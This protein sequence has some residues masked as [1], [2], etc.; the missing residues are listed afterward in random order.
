MSNSTITADLPRVE[1]RGGQGAAVGLNNGKPDQ[2][3]VVTLQNSTLS[4]GQETIGSNSD[5]TYYHNCF[6]TKDG[7]LH[8]SGAHN[9]YTLAQGNTGFSVH[10]TKKV[11]L[12]RHDQNATWGVIGDPV[13]IRAAYDCT[14]VLTDQGD[15]AVW[16]YNGHGQ[17]G[18]GHASGNGY[19]QG[20]TGTNVG[21]RSGIKG[22]EVVEIDLTKGYP[23]SGHTLYVRCKDGTV[24][25]WG[26]N[27]YGQ[28]G[29][30]NTSNCYT[31]VQLHDNTGSPVDD[32]IGIFAGHGNYQAVFVLRAD[33][34]LW[35]CGQNNWGKLGDG[36]TGNQYRLKPCVGLP[37]DS[38]I[39]K[40]QLGGSSRGASTYVL[41]KDGRVFGTGYGGQYQLN[42]SASN[43]SG[44]NQLAF[45]TGVGGFTDMWIAGEYAQAYFNADDGACY[46]CG[47]NGNGQLGVGSTSNA[48]MGKIN[49]P[50]GVQLKK[51]STG[52]AY[53]G[54]TQRHTTIMLG[55]DGE[56]YT[57]GH[58]AGYFFG[59]SGGSN[60]QKPVCWYRPW[61]K[62]ADDPLRR[63]VVD[64]VSHAYTSEW[65]AFVLLNNGE[66]WAAG[67]NS[68]NKLGTE[69]TNSYPTFVER[70]EIH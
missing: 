51:V 49:L 7:L 32:A 12:L 50:S 20:I 14:M 65:G 15:V 36:T 70:V 57:C 60:W 58:Y 42:A 54:A 31:P 10:D 17:Q 21:P 34:T 43:W 41:L 39:K 46:A 55:T 22:R 23:N 48:Y 37:A 27:G 13:A 61:P 62:Y 3:F 5:I 69:A 66:L 63:K 30:N 33:G 16:G 2:H 11:A 47:Y 38:P 26:Y 1:R 9:N 44:F 19:A 8:M 53:D 45:P 28:L 64:V 40:V 68:S 29:Q 35:S 59:N 6:L 67:R 18:R 24:W 4:G 56:V 25:G 52:G